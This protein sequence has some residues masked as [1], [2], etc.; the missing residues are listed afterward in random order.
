MQNRSRD[1]NNVRNCTWWC[2]FTI[3]IGACFNFYLISKISVMYIHMCACV[4]VSIINICIYF[5]YSYTS[6][7]SFFFFLKR[8]KNVDKVLRRVEGKKRKCGGA[9]NASNA[10]ACTKDRGQFEISRTQGASTVIRAPRV[11]LSLP[12]AANPVFALYVCIP[13]IRK[14]TSIRAFTGVCKSESG[15]LARILAGR[16][17]RCRWCRVPVTSGGQ[18][19]EPVARFEDEEVK[20]HRYWYWDILNLK[21][22]CVSN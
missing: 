15:N 14:Y 5:F 16:R 22:K 9:I 10:K 6:L 13:A 7:A 4:C 19:I 8:Y 1:W 18:V 20:S 17:Y 3:L 2:Y 11:L 12:P 21:K